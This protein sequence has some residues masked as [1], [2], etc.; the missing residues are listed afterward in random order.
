MVGK[1]RGRPRK[2]RTI[3]ETTSTTE[4]TR[5]DNG[6]VKVT[7]RLQNVTITARSGGAQTQDR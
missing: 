5:L 1:K 3:E 4:T 7:M 2:A 6:N